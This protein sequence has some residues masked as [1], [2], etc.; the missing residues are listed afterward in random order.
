YNGEPNANA[1][2]RFA[3]ESRTYVKM[4]RVPEEDQVF[5]VSYYLDGKALDFYNQ[6]VVPDKESWELKRFF[7]ELF[8]FCFPVDFRNTQRKR[9]NRCFQGVKEVSAHVAEWSEIY[10]TI[11]LEDNQEKVV[12]LFNSFTFAIQTEIYRKGLDP[13][14]STW[15]EVVKAAGEAEI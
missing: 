1:I 7:I 13:E 10:N 3:R 15:D 4:G 14:V 11:G 6:V 8:E 2:Q 5:F 12:K 9:L